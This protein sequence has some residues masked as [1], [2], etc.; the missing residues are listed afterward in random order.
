MA[1]LAS[2]IPLIA[3][4]VPGAPETVIRQACSLAAREFC[5]R[6]GA[7]RNELTAISI[8]ADLADYEVDYELDDDDGEAEILAPCKVVL[9]GQELVE[10]DDYSYGNST[11]HLVTT[12]TVAIT[13]GLEVTLTLRPIYGSDYIDDDLLTQNFEPLS[14]GARA[15]LLTQPKK[16]WSNPPLAAVYAARF[17]EE[18]GDAR[19][20]VDTGVGAKNSDSPN[21]RGASMIRMRTF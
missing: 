6:T 21:I 16:P 15:M 4:D 9:D 18:I 19:W 1:S 20:G 11:I 5:K 2:L 7:W 13:D 12:P 8:E 17:E 14:Y 3:L 10:G